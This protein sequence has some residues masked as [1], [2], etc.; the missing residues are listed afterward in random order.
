MEI[1]NKEFFGKIR[2]HIFFCSLG[3]QLHQDYS[4]TN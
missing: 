1:K 2:L 4:F 3:N